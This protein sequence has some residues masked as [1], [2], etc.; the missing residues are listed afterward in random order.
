MLTGSIDSEG[1]VPWEGYAK[2]P[3]VCHPLPLFK[4]TY[5]T[6]KEGIE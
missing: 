5:K 3:V 1:V 4:S 2:R 6:L